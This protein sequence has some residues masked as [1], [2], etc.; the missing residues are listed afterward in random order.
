V[1]VVFVGL[2][3]LVGLVVF[4]GLV[5]LVVLVVLKQKEA[6]RIFVLNNLMRQG[7]WVENHF[8]WPFW[9]KGQLPGA[10]FF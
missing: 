7:W 8:T 9:L 1:L 10:F 3:V 5:V 2:V 6:Q 4:V